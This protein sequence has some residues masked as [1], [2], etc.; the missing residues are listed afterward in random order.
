MPTGGISSMTQ[1]EALL[2]R[3]SSTQLEKLLEQKCVDYGLEGKT[4][5]VAELPGSLCSMF[6]VAYGMKIAH[7]DVVV[8]DGIAGK[9]RLCALEGPRLFL[10]VEVWLL[11]GSPLQLH[12]AKRYRTAGAQ[13]EAWPVDELEL[14][15]AWYPGIA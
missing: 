4:F 9:V 11:V 1:E 13:L 15:L 8:R 12:W 10:I 2:S 6:C 7:T 14:A 5:E 3:M